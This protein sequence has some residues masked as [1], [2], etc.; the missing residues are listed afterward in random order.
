MSDIRPTEADLNNTGGLAM[1][2][3]IKEA[4]AE[5]LSYVDD[6]LFVGVFGLKA[7]N[8]C[9]EALSILTAEPEPREDMETLVDD[10]CDPSSKL[11]EGETS[12]MDGR[13][14]TYLGPE[15]VKRA[16]E[17]YATRREQEA[18][19]DERRRDIAGE[20]WDILVPHI[21]PVDKHRSITSVYDEMRES[22]PI[23]AILQG[24]EPAKA[25]EDVERDL[26]Q[27]RAVLSLF[28]YEP[29]TGSQRPQSYGEGKAIEA[30]DIIDRLVVRLKEGNRGH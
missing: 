10:L 9:V 17:S 27:V 25:S 15:K 18:R 11:W 8:E 28:A 6:D 20:A 5:L 24:T 26:Q 1:D 3:R 12:D 2:S 29:R 21:R 7:K 19:A 22:F 23:P 14:D 30:L 4:Y 13:P 16:I